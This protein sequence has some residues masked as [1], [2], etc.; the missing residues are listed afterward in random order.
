VEELLAAGAA[1]ACVNL[2]GDLRVE[3][4]PQPWVI[5]VEDPFG[6]RPATR[7]GLKGGAVAT[8]SRLRRAWVGGHHVIDPARGR[9][10]TTDA[11][12]VTVLAA[13]AW[14][15]EALATAALVAGVEDGLALIE[16][17]GADGLIVDAW[18]GRHETSRFRRFTDRPGVLAS[19]SFRPGKV[20]TPEGRVEAIP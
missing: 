16:A 4:E 6:G 13:E 10:A 12:A 7:V 2:G 15:A 11:V 5:D 3:G 20:S 1:G 14:W 8:S 17:L 19:K 18:G 9:P